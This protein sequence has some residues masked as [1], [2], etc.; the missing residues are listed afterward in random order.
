VT[1]TKFLLFFTS[2]ASSLQ[3]LF[4]GIL[5]NFSD[6]IL[7]LLF[8]QHPHTCLLISRIL[9]LRLSFHLRTSAP[10]LPRYKC[11]LILSHLFAHH[12]RMYPLPL[13]ILLFFHNFP[14]SPGLFPGQGT[15]RTVSYRFKFQ[16]FNINFYGPLYN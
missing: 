15:A 8:C 9:I 5:L 16:I 14:A 3:S 4:L 12:V 1:G 6:F 11:S 10:T 7:S 2:L 13:L